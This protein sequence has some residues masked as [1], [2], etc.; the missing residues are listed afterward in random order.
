MGYRGIVRWIGDMQF[1]ARPGD[2]GCALIMGDGGVSPMQLLLLSA[3]GCTSYD[4]VMILKKMR[5][6]IEGLEVEVSGERSDEHP[7][8][9]TEIH[10]HYRLFG[11][12]DKKKVERAIELSQEKYCSVAAQLRKG[13]TEIT[14]SYEIIRE[15]GYPQ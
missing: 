14:Y 15:K 9:Y 7:R 4:V 2:E 11:N 10:L 12:L 8:V 13:G 3:A 6:P 5:Q 1:M